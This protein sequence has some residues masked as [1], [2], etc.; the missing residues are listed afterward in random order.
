MFKFI[1][2]L[3]LIYTVVFA[4]CD[5]EAYV[6]YKNAYED[7]RN[8]YLTLYNNSFSLYEKCT[9]ELDYFIE[10]HSNQ[11]ELYNMC[12]R[13]ISEYPN[14]NLTEASIIFE[15]EQ[16]IKQNIELHSTILQLNKTLTEKINYYKEQNQRVDEC[17]LNEVKLENQKE[18]LLFEIT[19]YQRDQENYENKL[20]KLRDEIDTLTENQNKILQ[21]INNCIAKEKACQDEKSKFVINLNACRTSKR[22]LQQRCERQEE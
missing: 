19:L 13:K 3:I 18:S 9:E 10:E 6:F 17:N 2:T 11:L 12:I 15:R 20:Q 7:I 8:E 4:K 5:E 1:T 21:N 22:R 16:L 14:T